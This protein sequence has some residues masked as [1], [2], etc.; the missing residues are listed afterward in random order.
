MDEKK[1]KRRR[2][3]RKEKKEN[4]SI[5]R[6]LT[7]TD[8]G[9]ASKLQQIQIERVEPEYTNKPQEMKVVIETISTSEDIPFN[10]VF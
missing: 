10:E 4:C 2:K 9:T 7:E 3:N 8:S 6:V 1:C 5:E